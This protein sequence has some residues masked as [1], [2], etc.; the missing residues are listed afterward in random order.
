[1][2]LILLFGGLLLLVLLGFPVLLAIGLT[3]AAGILALPGVNFALFAQRTFAMIDSF[4]LLALPYFI[5]AGALM[6]KGGLARA[7]V[8]FAQ[9]MVGHLRG[10]LGHTS[11]VTCTAMANV[12]GSSAA[13][14]ATVGSILIPEMKRRGYPGGLASAI[15]AISAIIGPI[16]PPSMTMIVYGAMTGVSI[17][18]LFLAGIVPGL[19]LAATLMTFIRLLAAT[20]RYP[21]LEHRSPRA[22]VMQ[23]LRAIRE[24]WVA[25]LAPFIIIGGIFAGI[26]TATEAGVVACLYSAVV[27]MLVY[28][29][30]GLKDLPAIILDAAVTTAMVVGI[31]AVTGALGWILSYV[32]F[33]DLV[34]TFLRGVSDNGHVVLLLMLAIVLV[35]TMFLESL[36]V[37]IVFV[38]IATYVGQ[39]YGFDPLHLGVLMILANQM[40]AVSPPV[41]VLMFITNA[42]AKVPY[43]ETVRH[44]APFLLLLVIYLVI[45][46]FVPQISTTVPGL[47]RP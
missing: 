13:E 9:T 32:S 46:V 19:L 8:R 17:G 5:L 34:L 40:G 31:I 26:F 39:A 28:R 36:S 18:G 20:G 27:S 38:P 42:I 3:S 4:S 12:S 21:A 16:I 45:L 14:A 11:V 35:L 6:A 22:T 25:L 44:A 23:M 2:T 47:L 37:L 15:V 10:S 29:E 30:I 41:A 33:N 43:L 24:V 7:L 1:M